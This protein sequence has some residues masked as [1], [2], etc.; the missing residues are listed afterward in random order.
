MLPL[1]QRAAVVLQPGCHQLLAGTRL[2]QQPV[3]NLRCTG[4]V[5]LPVSSGPQH[6]RSCNK[7]QH[8]TETGTPDQMAHLGE[9]HCCVG[10]IE[11]HHIMVQ[12]EPVAGRSNAW[13]QGRIWQSNN[14]N[15]SQA[16]EQCWCRQLIRLVRPAKARHGARV[17]TG[18][19]STCA[20]GCWG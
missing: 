4:L 10:L 5:N 13:R 20:W 1:G 9:R 15:S 11:A 6:A 14:S 19:T 2:A 17:L 16:E 8:E 7:Q 12:H 18:V 3:S